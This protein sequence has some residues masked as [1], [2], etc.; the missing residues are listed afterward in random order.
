MALPRSSRRS[1]I[2]T[3]NACRDRHVERIHET[4]DEGQQDD[5]PYSDDSAQRE[6]RQSQRLR[7]REDLRNDKRAV[8]V[9]AVRPDS[10]GRR[11][12]KRGD[13]PSES[14]DSQQSGGVGEAVDQ[15]AHGDARHPCPKKRDALPAEEQTVVSRPQSARGGQPVVHPSIVTP[16]Q[17]ARSGPETSPARPATS[18]IAGSRSGWCRAPRRDCGR[19]HG[20][21]RPVPS[22]ELSSA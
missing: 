11:Q 1:T 17:R 3:T 13:L 4:L 16:K 15:P 18:A 22:R 5:L 20:P 2:C 6:R 12:E 7:H 8:A 19:A 21:S 10:G 14:Y 9:P